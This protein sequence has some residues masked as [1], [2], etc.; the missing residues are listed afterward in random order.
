[1]WYCSSTA[2]NNG[3]AE[4][5]PGFG[6]GARFINAKRF[7]LQAV[8]HAGSL[9]GQRVSQGRIVQRR[10]RRLENIWFPI[11]SGSAV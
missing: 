5:I 9:P 6:N 10:W 1:M 4:G 7:F 11:A 8:V 3:Q 2:S